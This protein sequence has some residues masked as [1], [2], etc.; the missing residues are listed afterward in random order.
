MRRAVGPYTPIGVVLDP[1]SDTTDLL[2]DAASF[3]ISYNEEPHR[4]VYDRGRE[5]AELLLRIKAGLLVATARRRVPMILPAINMATDQ[6]PMADLHA[7][8]ARMEASPGN[9]DISLHGGFYGSDQPEAG[10]GVTCIAQDAALARA[11]VD[12]MARAAWLRRQEFLI[13]LV[14]PQQG[15]A[16]ALAADAPVGLID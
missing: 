7:I 12:V 9:I 6:G 15:V 4:D 16:V 10:F 13:D 14:T 11:T 8:R 2:L 3:T 5:A 1:H